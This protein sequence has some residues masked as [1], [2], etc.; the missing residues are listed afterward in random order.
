MVKYFLFLDVALVSYKDA[1]LQ[2]ANKM[3]SFQDFAII[4][5]SIYNTQYFRTLPLFLLQFTIRSLQL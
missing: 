3:T 1:N 2:N 4:S 5:T